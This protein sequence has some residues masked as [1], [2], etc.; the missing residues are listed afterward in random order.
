[1]TRKEALTR[2]LEEG[3]KVFEHGGAFTVNGVLLANYFEKA[4]LKT[5]YNEHTGIIEVLYMTY[6]GNT[7]VCVCV[8]AIKYVSVS[9]GTVFVT[10]D[11]NHCHGR[12]NGKRF[13]I[14]GAKG[15][16]II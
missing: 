10:N 16:E 15:G 7:L 6:E 12:I 2:V 14:E 1:M 4:K 9:V 13:C 8:D 3:I 5:D 11:E